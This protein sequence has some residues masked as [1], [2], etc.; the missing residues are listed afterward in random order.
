MTSFEYRDSSYLTLAQIM[1]QEVNYAQAEDYLQ[2]SNHMS[3]YIAVPLTIY[4][5][6]HALLTKFE[7]RLGD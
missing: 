6:F 5:H 2:L 1:E 4:N 7:S 3:E